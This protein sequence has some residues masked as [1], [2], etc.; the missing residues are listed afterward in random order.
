MFAGPGETTRDYVDKMLLSAL[1]E[2]QSVVRSYD[3]KAMIVGVGYILALNVVLRFGDFL[4][5]HAPIGPLF[6]AAVWGIAILP[7]LQFG[8]VLYPS[9]VRAQKE[10]N[11][12]TCGASAVPQFY[13]AD[14][15]SITNVRDL[16]HEALKSDWTSVVAAEL[17]TVSRVRVI[18][19]A[20]FNRALLMGVVSLAA[21]GGEQLFRSLK[22]FCEEQ[23]ERRYRSSNLAAGMAAGRS[24]KRRAQMKWQRK[25][26][27]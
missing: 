14:P 13:H 25:K 27:L 3:N 23:A 9:R 24:G 1:Q 20:R 21:L 7:I 10:L 2:A 4:P 11:D 8:Q 5:T 22:L 12:K 18:K 17:L 26:S 6:Y 16:V 19:Q 15:T